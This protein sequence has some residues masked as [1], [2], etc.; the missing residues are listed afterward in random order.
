MKVW[1]GLRKTIE[2]REWTCIEFTN[3]QVEALRSVNDY[4]AW[5]ENRH[6]KGRWAIYSVPEGMEYWFEEPETAT[7]F[8]LRFT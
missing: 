1:T 5:F 6:S 3:K 8:V 2:K 7:E 4:L